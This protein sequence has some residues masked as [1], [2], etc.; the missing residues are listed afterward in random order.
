MFSNTFNNLLTEEMGIIRNVQSDTRVIVDKIKLSIKNT[1][2]SPTSFDM[3]TYKNGSFQ[4]DVTISVDGNVSPSSKII[5]VNWYYFS[6][7]DEQ[8]KKDYLTKIPMRTSYNKSMNTLSVVVLAINGIIDNNTLEDSVAHEL[9]HN[10]QSILKGGE[11][12]NDKTK[13]NYQTANRNFASNSENVR[14]IAS[15][16]YLTYK[17]EQDAFLNGAYA[18]ILSEY[19]KN[20]DITDAYE[21]TEAYNSLQSLMYYLD[22]MHDA[23]SNNHVGNV[24]KDHCKSEYNMSFEKI[25]AIGEKAY[26]RYSRKLARMYAQALADIRNKNITESDTYHTMTFYSQPPLE[27]LKRTINETIFK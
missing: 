17:F 15:V 10:F 24:T 6:F 12:L 18:Y 26:S 19:E 5:K 13:A 23:L 21:K 4:I 1:S 14:I 25:L 27:D 22:I 7:S 16:I 8:T 3:T 11:L 20:Y 9:T 2:S